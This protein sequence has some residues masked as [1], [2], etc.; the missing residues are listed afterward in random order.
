MIEPALME[1]RPRPRPGSRS[2]RTIPE[3][4]RRS[5]SARSS[6]D[7]NTAVARYGAHYRLTGRRHPADCDR[8]VLLYG[9]HQLDSLPGRDA[10]RG[11]DD[12]AQVNRHSPWHRSGLPLKPAT[13]VAAPDVAFASPR[14]PT[15]ERLLFWPHTPLVKPLV[16]V[17]WPKTA[18]TALVDGVKALK[19]NP[20]PDWFTLTT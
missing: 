8:R 6:K 12:R 17:A 9:R 3:P 10:C 1:T 11:R 20:V 4:A 7:T 5:T 15:P 16:P 14:T 2:G 19:P 18:P 13:P